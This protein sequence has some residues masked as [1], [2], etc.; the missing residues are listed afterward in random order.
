MFTQFAIS[1]CSLLAQSDSIFSFVWHLK[2]NSKNTSA[3]VSDVEISWVPLALDIFVCSRDWL[4]TKCILLW[5]F[6]RYRA[7]FWIHCFHLDVNPTWLPSWAWSMF[8][9]RGRDWKLVASLS[10]SAKWKFIWNLTITQWQCVPCPFWCCS[11]S[12]PL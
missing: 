9:F 10:Q 5:A 6:S 12:P 3:L 8:G 2:P 11:A 4:N 1:H 7:S